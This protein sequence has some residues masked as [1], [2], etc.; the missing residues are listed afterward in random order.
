M[1]LNSDFRTNRRTYNEKG[2]FFGQYTSIDSLYPSAGV[3]S[4][5]TSGHILSAGINLLNIFALSGTVGGTTY[6]VVNTGS[7]GWNSNYT[8]VNTLSTGWNS[9]YTTVNTLSTGWNTVYTSYNTNSGGLVVN[10]LPSGVQGIVNY[11][12]LSGGPAIQLTLDQLDQTGSPKFSN[13][14]VTGNLSVLGELTFL[15][16]TVSV[17]SALSV[18]NDGSGPALFVRQSGVS[19]PIALF[20]D[21]EG[22]DIIFDDKGFL[23]LNTLTPGMRLTVG[24]SMS[25]S[26]AATL[27]GVTIT[28][29]SASG[30]STGNRVVTQETNGTLTYRSVAANASLIDGLSLVT[31]RLTKSSSTATTLTAS[32][33][34]DTGLSVQLDRNVAFIQRAGD[35]S[36]GGGDAVISRI[37]LTSQVATN[38]TTLSTFPLLLTP[39]QGSGISLLHSKYSVLLYTN[40]T[41]GT[42]RTC[43]EIAAG[44][45]TNIV[46]S[47]SGTSFGIVDI[48]STLLYD[49]DLTHSGSGSLMLTI[50]STV[51]CFAI[52]EATGF[53][54]AL[55]VA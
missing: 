48:G 46:G 45:N 21:A 8:T 6:T 51:A 11:F 16:T 41:G 34:V 24:G 37:T 30:T 7:A 54:G 17:T 26:G 52:I 36:A 12:E 9:N 42:Q 32:T 4:I 23:G 22:G 55:N 50:S 10:I 40:V 53:Y 35:P 20:K 3:Y 27:S 25:A 18:V 13:L 19:Q 5:N 47:V 31:N 1:S 14:T 39:L 28:A 15:N 44:S 29:L 43:Y 49:N 38:G 33:I 2:G